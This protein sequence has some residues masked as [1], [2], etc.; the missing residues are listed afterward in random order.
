MRH[1][2]TDLCD[3]MVLGDRGIGP[4][5]NPSTD[6]QELASSGHAAYLLT[7]QTSILKISSG[8][9]PVTKIVSSRAS[10]LPRL[11]VCHFMYRLRCVCLQIHYTTFCNTCQAQLTP[12]GPVVPWGYRMVPVRG[13]PDQFA[14]AAP[15]T[16]TSR[17]R[18]LP[19]ASTLPDR[20]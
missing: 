13:A 18:V 10:A 6:V 12:G 17:G 7:R 5:V 3:C 16:R 14:I 2:C 8:Q 4:A 9:E 20:S 15:R 1:M 19:A 11:C